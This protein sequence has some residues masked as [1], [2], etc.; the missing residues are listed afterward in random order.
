[1]VRAHEKLWLMKVP[2]FLME[3]L[4]TVQERAPGSTLGQVRVDSSG[5]PD[6]L[7]LSAADGIPQ[8]YRV[9]LE[10][11]APV[12]MHVLS[13]TSEGAPSIE[14]R[15][16][17]KGAFEAP[18]NTGYRRLIADRA[19]DADAARQ[20]RTIGI[21]H[22]EDEKALRR[23]PLD[24]RGMQKSEKGSKVQRVQRREEKRAAIA[25]AWMSHS[26]LRA[27]IKEC[28]SRQDFWSRRELEREL[29]NADKLSGC[30]E[31]LC[32][33]VTSRTSNHMGDWQLKP[34]LRPGGGKP[35]SAA[36]E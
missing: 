31:E 23:R 28:F 9:R 24:H 8:S 1:M 6:T 19:D 3:H 27:A 18:M 33:K 13:E 21:L 11:E 36:T 34:E 16:V 26:D 5:A 35:A 30:L 4:K 25:A 29:G 7:E 10:R 20:E 22:A 32:V 12:G 14:G 15:I 2:N 17:R